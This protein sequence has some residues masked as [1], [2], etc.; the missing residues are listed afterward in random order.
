MNEE[1]WMK[2]V[3]TYLKQTV[4][5]PPSADD[6]AEEMVK[7]CHSKESTAGTWIQQN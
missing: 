5:L 1:Q 3:P 6:G 4:P 7:G 2:L